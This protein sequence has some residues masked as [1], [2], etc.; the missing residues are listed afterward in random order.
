MWK[1]Q[2]H[3]IDFTGV[4]RFHSSTNKFL[5]EF[6]LLSCNQSSNLF[7][8]HGKFVGKISP[9]I[10][11][12]KQIRLLFFFGAAKKLVAQKISSGKKCTVFLVILVSLV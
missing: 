11:C 1:V 5:S 7:S 12:A 3:M 9:T 4:L 10:A 2:P 8:C 6:R